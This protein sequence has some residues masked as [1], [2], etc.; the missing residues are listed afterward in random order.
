M[1]AIKRAMSILLSGAMLM[2][3]LISP[4]TAFAGEAVTEGNEFYEAP[5]N[6]AKPEQPVT[7]AP[8]YLV[9]LPYYEEAGFMVD[10]GHV[11]KREDQGNTVLFYKAGDDVRITVSV[12]DGFKL[13]DLQVAD[14]GSSGYGYN[15]EKEDTFAFRMP[16]KDLKVSVSF[17]ERKQEETAVD[18]TAAVDEIPGDIPEDIPMPETTPD[19]LEDLPEAESGA[20]GSA[21]SVPEERGDEAAIAE[22]SQPQGITGEEGANVSEAGN[23]PPSETKDLQIPAIDPET[24][25]DGFPVGGSIV[26][27]AEVGISIEETQF[28][29]ETAFEDATYPQETCSVQMKSNT[30]EYGVPGLYDV[31]YRV[32]ESTT[33]RFWYVVRPV[34]VLEASPVTEAT[35]ENSTKNGD[36][37]ASS[38]RDDD[39]SHLSENAEVEE[40]FSESTHEGA[41]SEEELMTEPEIADVHETE[42]EST[43]PEAARQE[44]GSAS[45]H[46]ILFDT[47][48]GYTITM[49]NDQVTYQEG[50]EVSFTVTAKEKYA[51]RT[52]SAFVAMISDEAQL[53]SADQ[54][55]RDSNPTS[56]EAD[57]TSE[58][59]DN[60]SPV[61][62]TPEAVEVSRTNAVTE[63]NEVVEASFEFEMPAED[64]V[65]MA[66][67]ALAASASN[68]VTV[69]LENGGIKSIPKAW[70]PDGMTWSNGSTVIGYT[71]YRTVTMP[72]GK[73]RK[74]YCL[75]PALG[76]EED[77]EYTETEIRKKGKIS[78]A[79]ATLLRKGVF[80]CYGGPGW[81]TEDIKDILSDCS[82][83]DEYYV[84]THYILSKIY[85]DAT[86]G[87]WNIATSGGTDFTAVN[88]K[89]KQ[90]IED[91]V[92]KLKSL[93]DPDASLAP[94]QVAGVYNEATG[95][96]ETQAV[97]FSTN[98]T[99]NNLTT[100]LPAGVYLTVGGTT[101]N[102][103][104]KAQ[105][106]QNASFILKKNGYEAAHQ[107]TLNFKAAIFTD[108]DAYLINVADSKQNMGF[109]YVVDKGFEL[110]VN[111]PD[112]LTHL[113][114]VKQDALTGSTTP[115][116]GYTMDGAV[117]GI[118]ADAGK[119]Q[120][121]EQLTISNGSA[122]SSDNYVIGRTYYVAEISCPPE[123]QIDP[124]V[125]PV[126]AVAGGTATVT[127]S[128]VPKAVKI[129]VQKVDKE[130]GES[131]PQAK[132]L[133]F[134]GAV[135]GIYSDEACT[136]KATDMSGNVVADIR[137]DANGHAQSPQTLLIG[138]YYVKELAAPAGYLINDTVF[139]VTADQV[140]DEIVN[141][142]AD[143]SLVCEEQIIKAN[144]DLMKVKTKKGLNTE[145]A[146][147]VVF[148]FTYVNDPSVTF[149]VVDGMN[150]TVIT[151]AE[152]YATT[153]SD[154]YP[155]GT[156]IYGEWKIT[157][158]NTPEGFEGLDPTRF[159][160]AGNG[161]TYRFV[162]NN[163][164]I[165]A[166]V[167]IEKH[168]ANTGSR[169][170]VAGVKFRL[171]KDGELVK[172]FNP[173]TRA[174]EDT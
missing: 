24:E 23:T 62:I 79:E 66:S 126:M 87:N 148:T 171:F 145:A 140:R 115:T 166:A 10:E 146:E 60:V 88:A 1:T 112:L 45:V 133:S 20:D 163:R 50:D 103:G 144:M 151:D 100:T 63:G 99:N 124:N 56:E 7:E 164:Q 3:N 69:A 108:F 49:D 138:N 43:D 4:M 95:F 15:W 47:G 26:R 106:P 122:A 78:G 109:S 165:H 156:L 96:A 70:T 65:L 48:E 64:V 155:A 119:S 130:T 169:I 86:S 93:P 117:Y 73:E 127:S 174:Y 76:A 142:D 77:G 18:D 67:V 2:G 80:Y 82:S 131:V 157:E 105:I 143:V 58:T 162:A 29:P 68:D 170:P 111:W 120:L 14:T 52:A 116:P 134:E 27:F 92:A 172:L 118:Y 22:E 31:I 30:I 97:T 90:A 152:G 16:E 94:T 123:Y 38:E 8:D 39:P 5:V 9:T 89:G 54:A 46:N 51:I 159:M 136:V 113:N 11:K 19:A 147:G 17:Q 21:D 59:V 91:A 110:L 161:R 158:S 37:D 74:A 153:A 32:D 125:Y 25:A 132:G 81:A 121:L 160:I 129:S 98:V 35:T 40:S 168:D 107:E 84:A 83:N 114:I 71:R 44:E 135:F 167:L 85:C 141:Q 173:T 154:K 41:A 33:G 75:Q 28:I 13:E 53:S 72:D 137:T 12:R 128:D 150:N 61:V 34:R 55:D 149:S 139:P 101:Y 102:P 6:E 42:S 104:Q 57:S 36:S